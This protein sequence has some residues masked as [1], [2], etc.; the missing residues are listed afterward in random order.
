MTRRLR[1]FYRLALIAYLAL[2]AFL[3][4]GHFQSTPDIPKSLFGIPMDKI[5]H[6]LM[7]LPFPPLVYLAVDKYT[8]KPWH[9]LLF[10]LGVFALG[11]LLAASTEWIQGLTPYRSRDVLDFQADTLA[12]GIGTVIVFLVD[13][14][15]QRKARRAQG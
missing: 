4:L 5:V 13:V 15:K 3:C 7:F 2:V 9:S 1:T 14:G 8:V 6:F 10:A 11:C 12:L